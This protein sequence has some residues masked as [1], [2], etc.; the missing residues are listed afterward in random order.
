MTNLKK[1]LSV[2]LIGLAVLLTSCGD[3]DELKDPLTVDQE[4]Y[5]GIFTSLGNIKVNS[6]VT[7]LFETDDGDILYAY[8]DRYDLD[9]KDFIG[10]RVEAYGTVSTYE[11]LDKP[12]FNVKRISEAKEEDVA[13]DATLLDYKNTNF[14]V[15]FSYLSSWELTEGIDSLT[16]TAPQVVKEEEEDT[17][18]AKDLDTI[19]I[20]RLPAGL[21]KTS[22]DEE[23]MRIEEIEAYTEQEYPDLAIYK[24]ETN[25]VGVDQQLA[26]KYK[27]ELSDVYYFVP[28]ASD[29]YEI[30]FHHTSEDDSVLLDYTNLFSNL[31]ASFRFLPTD[32][33]EVDSTDTTDTSET[34]DT[35]LS[36]TEDTGTASANQVEFAKYGSFDSN[37]GFSISYPSPWY[38]SGATGKYIFAEEEIED[39][40]TPIITL[41]W[42]S[43]GKVGTV[44]TSTDVS[45]TAQI[46]SRYYTLK[47]APE[48]ENVMQNMADSI[49]T[50]EE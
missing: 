11:A 2:A 12:L 50:I 10:I 25:Y 33:S 16:L 6:I 8:S 5:N 30:S 31:V 40:T 22:T 9:D 39:S 35:T 37:F 18:E 4:T 19:W 32:G 36:D 27:T 28:R 41:S 47:G 13:E 48:Y 44:R 49:K 29:I 1:R 45:I 26:V 15:S 38:Y 46:D 21:T 20:V 23:A 7:H 24:S 3:A 34:T 17:E 43:T 42:G 14:G